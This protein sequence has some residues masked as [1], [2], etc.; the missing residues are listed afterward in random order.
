MRKGA[1]P[2]AGDRQL[3]V[4]VEE[5]I[6]SYVDR[7][8]GLRWAN[9]EQETEGAQARAFCTA[10]GQPGIQSGILARVLGS[11]PWWDSCPWCLIV[12]CRFPADRLSGPAD[13]SPLLSLPQFRPWTRSGSSHLLRSPPP[14]NSLALAKAST[15]NPALPDQNEPIPSPL[16]LPT[17]PHW[18][19]SCSA[20]TCPVSF[21][22]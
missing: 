11:W 19:S 6:A 4:L 1:L 5:S 17:P 14:L 12:G 21:S 22:H 15:P 2:V 8:G 7:S 13:P 9:E 18:D 10:S 3:V 16:N 20:E